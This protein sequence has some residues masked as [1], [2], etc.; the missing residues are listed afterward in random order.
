[1]VKQPMNQIPED[2]DAAPIK[3]DEFNDANFI[4]LVHTTSGNLPTL[5]YPSGSLID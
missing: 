4:P 2:Q 3:P 1:M 5:N